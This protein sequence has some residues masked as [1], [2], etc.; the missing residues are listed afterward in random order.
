V[1]PPVTA[2]TPPARAEITNLSR[3]GMGFCAKLTVGIQMK[4]AA[5][6]GSR[7]NLAFLMRISF[8]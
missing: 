4:I 5:S 1:V 6:V 3:V 7:P 8:A 2:L